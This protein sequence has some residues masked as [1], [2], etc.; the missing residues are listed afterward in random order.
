MQES[1]DHRGILGTMVI[2][3][4]SGR[5]PRESRLGIGDLSKRK[6][7]FTLLRTCDDQSSDGDP[8]CT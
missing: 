6:K 3:M 5:A 4:R 2:R 8:N 7:S 1:K